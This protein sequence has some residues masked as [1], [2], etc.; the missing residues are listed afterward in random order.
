M[1]LIYK[2][3]WMIIGLFPITLLISFAVLFAGGTANVN[4]CLLCANVLLIFAQLINVVYAFKNRDKEVRGLTVVLLVNIA[5]IWFI[6]I[7]SWDYTVK[8]LTVGFE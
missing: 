1:K 7:T 5:L 6:Y 8:A 4:R 2:A 3:K